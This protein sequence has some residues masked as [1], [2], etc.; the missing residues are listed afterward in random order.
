[1][2]ILKKIFFAILVLISV[3]VII[4]AIIY[5][6]PVDPARLTFG[7]RADQETVDRKRTELHLDKP[8]YAQIAH[9]LNDVSP[10]SWGS[11]DFYRKNNHTAYQLTGSNKGIVVKAPY[12]RSSYQSGKPVLL[13]L[14]EAIP[15]TL[16]LA[17]LAI[18]IAFIIGCLL[19]TI[20]AVMKDTW[21]DRS[22]ITLT[23]LG[24]SVPSYVSAIL[25]AL[26]FGYLLKDY[27][28]LN[29]QGSIFDLDDMGNN[30]IYFK[31]LI[32]PAIA[33]GV[34]P[35]S[36]IT[37]LMRS[38]LLDVMGMD[39]IRTA[40]SKGLTF[41]QSIKKHAVKNALNPV[42]TA[43]SGW[44]ASLLAGA[45]FVEQVFNF[46]GVGEL[47]VNALINYDVPVVL[48]CTI[49]ISFVFIVINLSMDLIYRILDPK[50]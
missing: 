1:M 46:K 8:L 30:K 39:Y 41:I 32:L 20:S 15:K 49:F 19:G 12:L 35:L 22:I 34:R 31:N 18:I 25:L 13:L 23:V 47:T 36:V 38:S 24:I 33:L 28:G 7:Q 14:K 11:A 27:T 29:I 3:I 5:T 42:L 17:F 37:Q 9:Y 43:A 44:F 45:F 40:Q 6:A 10:I 21:I 48:G 2:L 26:V 4:S 16:I 50:V